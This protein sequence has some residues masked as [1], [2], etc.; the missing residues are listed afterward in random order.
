MIE[1]STATSYR[2]IL[3]GNP[4]DTGDSVKQTEIEFEHRSILRTVLLKRSKTQD[5]AGKLDSKKRYAALFSN[6]LNH[7]KFS[8]KSMFYKGAVAR[9]LSKFKQMK[10]PPY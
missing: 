8:M 10:P 3:R 2:S 6:Y 9:N 7:F 1:R 4:F 5:F